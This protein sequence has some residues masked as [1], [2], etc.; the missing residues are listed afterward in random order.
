[1]YKL[2]LP[3]NTELALKIFT[4]LN[5]LLHSGFFSNL[6]LPWKTKCG[7]NSLYWTYTFYH[8]GFL[9]T[10]RLPWKT[11]VALTVYTVLKYF[12]HSGFLSNLRLPWKQSLPWIHS[13]EYIFFIIQDFWETCACPEKHEVQWQYTLYWNIFI[14]Q[15]F[16]TTCACF[17]NRV[18]PEFTVLNIYFLSFRIFE[19]LALVMK[20]EFVLKFFKT[21]GRPPRPRTPALY[22]YELDHYLNVRSHHWMKIRMSAVKLTNPKQRQS[23]VIKSVL[24]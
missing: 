2:R 6:P 17:E 22:A 11:R 24:L 13:I 9:S 23:I 12:Y 15:D 20:T 3:W 1:M 14:I 19:Q 16:W 7:L 4:A 21:G 18:C 5:I 10:L 8:S